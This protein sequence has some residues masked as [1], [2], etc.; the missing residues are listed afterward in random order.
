MFNEKLENELIISDIVNVMGDYVAIQEDMDVGN[1]KAAEIIAQRVDL[2]RVIGDDNVARCVGATEGA[3]LNL[4]NLVVP[5]LC[6]FTYSR[7]LKMF[8]GTFTESGY[9]IDPD[10]TDKGTAKS[11]ANEHASLGEIFLRDVVDFLEIENPNDEDVDGDKI[12]PR[13][14]VFGGKEFR[15]SN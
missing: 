15:A 9:R 14:R 7:L 5:A 10:V 1:V 8:P 13:I 12:H 11:V 3:D 4:K 6:Y 2:A